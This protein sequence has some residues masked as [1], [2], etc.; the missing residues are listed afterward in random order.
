MWMRTSNKDLFAVCHYSCSLQCKNWVPLMISRESTRHSGAYMTVTKADKP[1]QLSYWSPIRRP[2]HNC[3]TNAQLFFTCS[4]V[5]LFEFL[6]PLR[7]TS[8]FY[9]SLYIFILSDIVFLSSCFSI[10]LVPS[11]SLI[12]RAVLHLM[13][14]S[15]CCWPITKHTL[16]SREHVLF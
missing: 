3:T 15:C 11:L 4:N 13:H 16:P 8:L 6:F 5:L 9:R 1:P 14:F 10:S 7:S 2:L 12:S